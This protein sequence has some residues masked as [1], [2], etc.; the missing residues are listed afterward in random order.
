MDIRNLETFVM[1]AELL[2]FTRAAERLGYTQ[3]TVSFQIRQLEQE[4]GAP[5]FERVNRA[6]VLTSAGE[7][8]LPISQNMIRLRAEASYLTGDPQSPQGLVRIAIAESLANW[9]LATKF[10]SFHER[11]PNIHLKLFSGS[12]EDMFRVLAQNQADLVYTLDQQMFDRQYVVAFESPISMSFVCHPTHPLTEA[13]QVGMEELLRYPL[14]LT[15]KDMSYR[16]Q[17]DDALARRGRESQPLVEVGD[18]HLICELLR[19]GVGISVLPD[20]VT[21]EDIACGRLVRLPVTDIRFSIWRQLLY[22]RRKWVSPEMRCVIDFF[23]DN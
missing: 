23:K 19:Q 1:A 14:I 8:L 15:E 22:N 21:A 9:Q 10:R 3:S 13:S 16:A 11:Y 5:L 17:L 6:V 4:L 12:T 18:T 2:S 20:Y 7:K